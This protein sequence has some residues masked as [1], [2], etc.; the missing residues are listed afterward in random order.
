MQQAMTTAHKIQILTAI[1]DITAKKAKISAFRY[2]HQAKPVGM[3][4]N[5]ERVDWRSGNCNLGEIP[6]VAHLINLE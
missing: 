6:F 3:I 5:H 4:L 2:G 1:C